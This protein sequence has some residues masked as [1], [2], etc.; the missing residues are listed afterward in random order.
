[1]SSPPALQTERKGGNLAP[2]QWTHELG[3]PLLGTENMMLP[4]H[5]E[6]SIVVVDSDLGALGEAGFRVPP[7]GA[8][9]VVC[10][11]DSLTV[12][13]E[14]IFRQRQMEM[15][16]EEEE[17]ESE[18]EDEEESGDEEEDGEEAELLA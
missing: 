18:D 6:V 1:M 17:E 11:Q 8:T 5:G 15:D 12:S 9:A 14:D 13:R 4:K 3:S 7:D 2:R 10:E 16:A